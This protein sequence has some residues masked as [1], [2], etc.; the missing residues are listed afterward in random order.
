MENERIGDVVPLSHL[1]PV[2]DLSP[3]MA[4]SEIYEIMQYLQESTPAQMVAAAVQ[5]PAEASVNPDGI[6]PAAALSSLEG[7]I[8]NRPNAAH[9]YWKH[10]YE[11][12]AA[13]RDEA[14]EAKNAGKLP[15][16]QIYE[17]LA[18]AGDID[19]ITGEPTQAQAE[20]A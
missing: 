7:F 17:G 8:S 13:A 1:M 15:P 3:A 16:S 11:R 20:A 18:A 14:Q 2:S 4:M 5:D 12:M 6:T 9:L 10:R 19:Y